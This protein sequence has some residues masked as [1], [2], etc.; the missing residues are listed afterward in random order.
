MPTMGVDMAYEDVFQRAY[1]S[2]LPKYDMSD[3]MSWMK[4]ITSTS[5]PKQHFFPLVDHRRE[6]GYTIARSTICSES[7]DEW[8]GLL[9]LF[10]RLE[11]RT[12]HELET[13][14]TRLAQMVFI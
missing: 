11:G 13:H 5:D 12:E 8:V 6:Y 4:S 3:P 9:P 7:T 1:Q 10:D 2:Y 14:R